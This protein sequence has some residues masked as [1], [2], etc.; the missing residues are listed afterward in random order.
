MDYS[1]YSTEELEKIL[2][3]DYADYTEESL[4]T[5]K[6]LLSSRN[7]GKIGIIHKYCPYCKT[8]NEINADNCE[9]G[10][11]FNNPNIEKLEEEQQE[12]SIGTRYIGIFFIIGG[13]II[14][15]I[16]FKTEINLGEVAGCSFGFIMICLGVYMLI[17]GKL[18]RT[19]SELRDATSGKYEDSRLHSKSK[20][21]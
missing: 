7:D 15:I 20:D 14:N 19:P 12:K 6:K 3:R 10:Y 1:N 16:S 11:D 5:I 18:A 9:C 17:T 2:Y 13:L 8:L 4:G 21:V